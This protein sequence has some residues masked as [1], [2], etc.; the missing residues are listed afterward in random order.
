MSA[1]TTAQAGL[2]SATSTWTGGVKPVSGDTVT[3]NHAVTVDEDF[4]VGTSPTD[5]TG[6]A[7]LTINAAITVNTGVTLKWQ[8]P[9]RQGNATVT[10]SA[11]STLTYDSSG[12]GAPT[13]AKYS[14]QISQASSQANAKLVFSGSS[15]SRCTVNSVSNNPSGAFGNTGTNWLDGGRVEASY[16]DFSYV[17]ATTSGFAFLPRFNGSAGRFIL[18]HCTVDHCGKLDHSNA[19]PAASTYEIL[20]TRITNSTNTTTCIA[21]DASTAVTTGSRRIEN[22]IIYGFIQL[23]GSTSG[24][25]GFTLKNNSFRKRA[26]TGSDIVFQISGG[27]ACGAWD[28]N[29]VFIA[30]DDTSNDQVRVPAGA[31]TNSY[32]FRHGNPSPTLSNPHPLFIQPA[33]LSYTFS[34]WIVEYDGTDDNGDMIE[35]MNDTTSAGALVVNNCIF[36]PG[37]LGLTTLYFFFFVGAAGSE[38]PP[39]TSEDRRVLILHRRN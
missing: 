26:Y 14:W 13:T 38:P 18:D 25:T 19:L 24:N 2:K 11:G 16:T 3:V 29:L 20:N 9:V 7:A 1:I 32:L 33:A 28:Q 35:I 22:S 36:L 10:F 37:G 15:G 34:G 27:A 31:L 30:T 17:G 12:A 6:T 5:D 8:G 21:I 23:L 39:P 4:T